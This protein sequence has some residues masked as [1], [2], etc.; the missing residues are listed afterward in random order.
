VQVLLMFL[1][2]EPGT[3]DGIVGK[4]TRSAILRF[5]EEHGLGTSD[6]IDDTLVAALLR[7]NEHLRRGP[8]NPRR[9]GSSAEGQR[10]MRRVTA[11]ALSSRDDASGHLKV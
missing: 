3:I 10:R 4:R 6:E 7:A 1:G 11:N 9:V 8:R 2:F 5:R